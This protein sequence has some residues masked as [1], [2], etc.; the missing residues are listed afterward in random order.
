MEAVP[1]TTTRIIVPG[2]ILFFMAECGK[3]AL[4]QGRVGTPG[5][6]RFGSRAGRRHIKIARGLFPP[7]GDLAE[8]FRQLSGRRGTPKRGTEGRNQRMDV[9]TEL[10]A[11]LKPLQWV[12]P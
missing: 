11:V 1:S 9:Y 6:A 7:L 4:H 5:V 10:A 12:L 2:G 3:E 8:Q